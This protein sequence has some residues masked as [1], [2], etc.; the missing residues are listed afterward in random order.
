M[1]PRSRDS[2]E[3]FLKVLHAPLPGE[4]AYGPNYIGAVNAITRGVITDIDDFRNSLALDQFEG[5][6]LIAD[7]RGVPQCLWN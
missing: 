3:Q 6:S 4:G 7:G 2:W 1:T 5:S